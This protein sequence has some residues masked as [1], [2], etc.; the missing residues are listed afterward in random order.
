MHG[1]CI[2]LGSPKMLIFGPKLHVLAQNGIYGG[3]KTFP[4]GL[5][6]W[7][8]DCVLTME[9]P[10]THYQNQEVPPVSILSIYLSD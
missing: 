4:G 8:V 7:H 10:V 1:Q 9:Q 2:W 5:I 3:T 6:F